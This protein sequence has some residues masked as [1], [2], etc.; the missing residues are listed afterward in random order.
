MYY[1]C[2]S[3]AGNHLSIYLPLQ[4]F[5]T[6]VVRYSGSCLVWALESLL[7][8]KQNI[9]LKSYD[10]IWFYFQNWHFSFNN[11]FLGPVLLLFILYIP[12]PIILLFIFYIRFPLGK[13]LHPLMIGKG[14]GMKFQALTLSSWKTLNNYKFNFENPLTLTV[15]ILKGWFWE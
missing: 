14:E 15:F 11:K 12:G 8:T 1:E 10:F 5:R 4:P 2:Q 3:V 7:T 6:Q 9:M 13:Y